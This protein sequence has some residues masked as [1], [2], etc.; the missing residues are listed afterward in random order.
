[1]SGE[2]PPWYA[3]GL[4]FACTRCGNCCTGPPGAVWINEAEAR[5]L[6]RRLE[7]TLDQFEILNA[8]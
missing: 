5:Q 4:R 1:M 3:D 7:L 8:R 6:A 2:A